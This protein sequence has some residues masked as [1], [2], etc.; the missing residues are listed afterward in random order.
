MHYGHAELIVTKTED[1]TN[2]GFDLK[3]VKKVASSNSGFGEV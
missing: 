2:E 3:N 1:I